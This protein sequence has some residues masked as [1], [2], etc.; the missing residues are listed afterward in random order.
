MDDPEPLSDADT[1]EPP[2]PPPPPHPPPPLVPPPPQ[3]RLE[4]LFADFEAQL[5]EARTQLLADFE[6]RLRVHADRA[7]RQAATDAANWV[8][9]S[10]QAYSPTPTPAHDT[11]STDD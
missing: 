9:Q 4:E 7:I 6:E 3:P 10:L 5:A 2:P 1:I 11:T 8:K